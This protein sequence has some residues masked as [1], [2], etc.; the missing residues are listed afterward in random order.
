MEIISAEQS[1]KNGGLYRYVD[2]SSLVLDVC[3]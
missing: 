1:L 2:F 3:T